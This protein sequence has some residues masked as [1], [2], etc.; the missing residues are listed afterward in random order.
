ME[1]KLTKYS[2]LLPL[3]NSYFFLISYRS[4][5]RI[6]EM[7]VYMTMYGRTGYYVCPRCRVTLERDYMSFCDRCGQRLNWDSSSK[8]TIRYPGKTGQNGK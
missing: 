2:W 6:T 4:P 8:A 3:F 7:M 1:V 5:M